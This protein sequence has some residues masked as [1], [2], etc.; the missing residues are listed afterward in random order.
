MP[1]LALVEFLLILR[2]RGFNDK[3]KAGEPQAV[4]PA[5]RAECSAVS[6]R[7]P[8]SYGVPDFPPSSCWRHRGPY[9]I[10]MAPRSCL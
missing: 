2:D 8:P 5:V 1:T 10:P 3:G 6:C 9:D 7:A 4:V